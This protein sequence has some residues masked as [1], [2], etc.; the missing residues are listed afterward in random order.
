MRTRVV[1]SAFFLI[2][3]LLSSPTASQA[4][5]TC[6]TGPMK[7]QFVDA[8]SWWTQTPGKTGDNFGHLH[9]GACLPEREQLASVYAMPVRVIMHKNPGKFLHLSLVLKGTDY[10]TTVAKYYLP[11][12]SCPDSTCERN[13]TVN[14]DPAKFNHSGLQ[15]IRLRAYVDE[16]DGN[17]MAASLNTQTYVVNAKSKADVSRQPYLRGKGWYTGT[18][19]C[20]ASA[21]S[22]PIP[23]APL[24]GIWTPRVRAVWHGTSADLPIS[25][26]VVLIDPN[27]HAGI[28]GTT[29]IA[30]AGQFDSAVSIDTRTLLNGPHTLLV[31]SECDDTSSGSTNAGVL[32]M[33]FNVQ[34]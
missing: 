12:F 24:S 1:T 13:I 10:E 30:G 17:R 16:P 5:V 27:L 6:P 7:T 22:V 14:V 18:G 19:Y 23:D 21:P 31:R 9:L 29:V 25:R 11:D 3:S 20:E 4:A 26:H 34:N 8:Q 33:P 15:E 32:V 28:P 2:L